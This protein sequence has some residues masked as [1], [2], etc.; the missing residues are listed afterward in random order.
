MKPIIIMSNP[1]AGQPPHQRIKVPSKLPPLQHHLQS[2]SLQMQEV[3]ENH[4]HASPVKPQCHTS[5]T[6]Q[7]TALNSSAARK[8]PFGEKSSSG[9]ASQFL[10]PGSAIR[11]CSALTKQRTP[12]KAK[13]WMLQRSYETRN[14]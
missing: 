5:I 14:T 3:P 12:E 4:E 10:N 13:A 2:Q 1:T 9:L 7:S 6:A 8:I 11:D